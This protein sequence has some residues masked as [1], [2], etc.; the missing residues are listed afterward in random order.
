MPGLSPEQRSSRAS[1]NASASWAKTDDWSARTAPAR[2]AF[3]DRFDKQV[4]PDGTLAPDARARR[5]AHARRAYFLG[6][7]IKSADARRKGG[8]S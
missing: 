5:A 2:Q 1:M 7:A 3:L 4:D 8:A 6:L